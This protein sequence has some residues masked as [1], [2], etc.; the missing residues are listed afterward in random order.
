MPKLTRTIW[1]SYLYTDGT[2]IEVFEE[3]RDGVKIGETA[4][5]TLG[6][7]DLSIMR[8]E[9]R[10]IWSPENRRQGRIVIGKYRSSGFLQLARGGKIDATMPS[11]SNGSENSKSK[12]IS[13]QYVTLTT[14]KGIKLE[15]TETPDIISGQFTIQDEN[16]APAQPDTL[17]SG[18]LWGC[19]ARIWKVKDLRPKQQEAA[20][21]A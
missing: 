4:D 13:V 7:C 3:S 2:L 5:V 19:S 16:H 15:W 14:A 8:H 10:H 11:L 9:D 1:C 20:N 17:V 18:S 12:G 21:A 6:Y